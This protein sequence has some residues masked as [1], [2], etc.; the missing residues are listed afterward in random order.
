MT[1]TATSVI[2][3]L[4]ILFLFFAGLHFGKAFLMPLAIGALLATL[5]LP[6]CKWLEEKKLHKV[7]AA[8]ICVLVLLLAIAGV[9]AL[10]GWQI[11][12]LS[13]DA[14]L[15]KQKVNEAISHIKEFINTH[16][17]ISPKK[18]EEMLQDQQQSGILTNLVGSFANIFTSLILMN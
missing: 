8:L 3:Q 4:L 10:V 7:L 2:K 9:G 5:F 6:F 13:S 15:I 11:S 1:I 18:Q 17:G 16:L 12:E 14:A